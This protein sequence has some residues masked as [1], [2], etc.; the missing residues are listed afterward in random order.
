MPLYSS[1][2]N[3]F[4]HNLSCL[5]SGKHSEYGKV[6]SIHFYEARLS[7][8]NKEVADLQQQKVRIMKYGE[9][10]SQNNTGFKRSKQ[11]IRSSL[12]SGVLDESHTTIDTEE[13]SA[14]ISIDENEED[15]ISERLLTHR[16]YEIQ[17]RI[18]MNI[19]YK[20]MIL[21]I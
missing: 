10:P 17:A 7:S 14:L 6:D 12:F 21:L 2:R 20:L 4:N 13:R 1:L 19:A 5:S 11:Y 18:L 16:P 9:R 15:A 3:I 8:L